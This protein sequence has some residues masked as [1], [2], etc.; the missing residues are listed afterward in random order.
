MIFIFSDN[1]MTPIKKKL[2]NLNDSNRN[3]TKGNY[4][5]GFS[6]TYIFVRWL[7]RIYLCVGKGG[8]GG[9]VEGYTRWKNIAPWGLTFKF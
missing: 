6:E 1:I 9:G 3:K 8:W 5:F 7:N 2:K 4:V